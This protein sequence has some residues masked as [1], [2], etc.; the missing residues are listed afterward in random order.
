MT[1]KNI[2]SISQRNTG[3][4]P[5]LDTLRTFAVFLVLLGHWMSEEEWMKV[6]PYGML[7]VTLFFVLSG[8]L[9]T[10][11]LIKSRNISDQ[12]N[13]S[14]FH[15]A[16]QFYIR[17]T[18]RIFPIYYIT[19]IVLFIFNIQ[20]IRSVFL[21]FLF[22]A[23]NIYFFKI[24]SWQ[25]SLSHLWTLAVEEQFY[26]IWPF[27]ILF[28][29]GKYLYRSIIGIIL[30][31]P[32]FRTIIFLFSRSDPNFSD[33]LTPACMDYFGLGALLAYFRSNNIQSLEF[34]NMRIK[35]FLLANIFSIIILYFLSDN[36]ITETIFK[37]NIAVICLSLI[38]KASTGFSGFLKKVF[39]NSVLMYLG[40]ISYGLYLFHNFIPLVYNVLNL[41]P[42]QNVYFKF[43]VQAALLVL[44]ASASWFA[45]ERPINNLKRYFKYN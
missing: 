28:I 2:Q 44:I 4:M 6:F 33:I 10:G 34:K 27:I 40:K 13:E 39:E 7:G 11:I 31:G 15:S 26:I 19:L 8:F 5:Q 36:L 38:S 12:K 42:I 20:N 18:L 21:W 32:V 43:S 35:L 45:I 25:G 17:R 16:K 30:I 9:I 22:Y 24:Q 29:P 1:E 3:Y 41:P 37:F 14:K 23:S